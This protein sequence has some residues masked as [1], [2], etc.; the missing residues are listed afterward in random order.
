[1]ND[2]RAKL[3]FVDAYDSFSENIISLLHEVLDVS[4]TVI[5]IDT[6]IKG[7]HGV[8][9]SDYFA[10]FHAIVLGPGPGDPLN[11]ADIGLFKSVWAVAAQQ[12]IPV[13]GICLGFQSLCATY[14]MRITRLETP[15]HGHAK[16]IYSYH[17]DIFTA[18]GHVVATCYNSLGIRRPEPGWITPVSRPLSRGSDCSSEAV[19][20]RSS[21]EMAQ[22]YGIDEDGSGL[23]FLAWD[24]DGWLQGVRHA[25]L[26]FW[27]LQF[28]PESCK[29]NKV[30]HTIIRNWFGLG[31]VSNKDRLVASE[32]TAR[33]VTPPARSGAPPD[34]ENNALLRRLLSLT[35]D[36]NEVISKRMQ[37]SLD[38]R[39]MA[40][41]CY[42][43]SNW[44]RVAMLESSKKGRYS[45]YAFTDDKTWTL[46]HLQGLCKVTTNDHVE[47]HSCP[48]GEAMSV[49]EYL[50][51]ARLLPNGP[52]ESPFWGGLVGYFSYE[53]GLDLLSIDDPLM[54]SIPREV[55][56]YSLMWVDRSIVIDKI[57]GTVHVQSLR[58]ND[59]EWLESTSKVILALATYT[60]PPL[61]T[62]TISPA[63]ATLPS[64]STY[65][66]QIASC[67]TQLHA[68][69]SYELCL[70]TSTPLTLPADTSPFYLHQQLLTHNPSTYSALLVLPS[71]TILSSSP[72]HF[73]S[74]SRPGLIFPDTVLS[75]MPM[76]GT[77][78]KREGMT[79]AMAE[80]LLRTPKEEAENLMIVDLIRHDLA[81]AL[82][83]TARVEI[84]VP[85]LF[86]L[87]EAE[88]VY[89]LIS[90]IRA[91][92]PAPLPTPVPATPPSGPP[93]FWP[94]PPATVLK[95]QRTATL[96]HA[97][98]ALRSTLPPGSM[99]GAPK[100]RSCEIL[101][102]L[103]RRNRGVYAGVIGY[104]DVGG[105][106]CWSVAIRCAFSSNSAR[107]DDG[108]REWHVGAGGA[109][110]VLSEIEGEWEEM[111]VKMGSVLRGFGVVEG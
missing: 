95:H 16:P 88:T 91:R 4:V 87:V 33:D 80:K 77:L 51:N 29:S 61:R 23:R 40:E 39:H 36:R 92:V 52:A 27:G 50:M 69:N 107:R 54:N 84:T 2:T 64:H 47:S 104:L 41:A 83:D 43:L 94:E 34:P 103:E 101:R 9:D 3:L 12:K 97:M 109:I 6:D 37:L 13:L 15:C 76:K 42:D 11:D 66:S 90:H 111:Q 59:E 70:T 20:R 102:G 14:G 58:P 85:Q 7:R 57:D 62:P 5:Q 63:K 17:N 86:A 98:A 93:T 99:T 100:K 73:L 45:I 10:R 78:A 105:G 8:S 31:R 56:D 71:V 96:K 49:I 19:S 48:L 79:S 81:R 74:W 72:E 30:C 110:T 75:M 25:T 67:L 53:M 68:G 89:Q 21:L 32:T 60:A 106:G 28:H 38:R 1:M 26:P 44:E 18:T 65:T 46:E 82:K 55:P 22:N 35:S 108:T 24:D